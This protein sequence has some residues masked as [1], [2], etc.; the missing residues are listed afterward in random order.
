[1]LGTVKAVVVGA[2]MAVVIGAVMAVVVSA[3]QGAF[4]G[5]RVGPAVLKRGN[6]VDF[7]RLIAL[8]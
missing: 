7:S 2:V 6:L 1:M 5:L 3:V 4:E 8:V